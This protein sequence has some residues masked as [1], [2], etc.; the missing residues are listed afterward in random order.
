MHWEDPDLLV[1]EL[2]ALPSL[3]NATVESTDA[4][5][6]VDAVV[7]G[8]PLLISFSYVI[9]NKKPPFY[10]FGRSKKLEGITG[11][12]LNRILLR[13]QSFHWFLHGVPGLGSHVDEV[14]DKLKKLIAA[15]RPSQVWCIG[16]SMGGYAA[17][18]FGFL[19]H[20]DRIVAISPLSNFDAAQA[21]IYHEKRFMWAQDAVAVCP[22]ASG[23]YDLPQLARDVGYKGQLHLVIG[24]TGNVNAPDVVNID[25]MHAYRFGHVPGLKMYYVPEADHDY[26]TLLLQRAGK[27]DGVLLECLFDHPAVIE[28]SAVWNRFTPRV[29]YSPPGKETA[30][31]KRRRETAAGAPA[32]SL[33][34]SFPQLDAN[35]VAAAEAA[36]K[37]VLVDKVVQHAPLLICFAESLP[38]RNTGFEFFATSKTL[39]SLHGGPINRVLLRDP[40]CQWWLRGV[41]ELGDDYAPVAQGLKQFIDDIEPERV[42]CVGN[43]MG[44]YAAIMFAMLLQADHA[45]ALNPLSLLDKEFASLCHDPRHRDPLERLDT[46]PAASGPRDLLQLADEQAYAGKLDIL[47][48]TMQSVQ[49]WH[50]G[51]HNAVHAARLGLLPNTKLHPWYETLDGELLRWLEYRKI[52]APQLH[53]VAF[54]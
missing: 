7:P 19:L 14:A 26:V 48:S 53:R 37:A 2:A 25:V 31:G 28:S 44:A 43:G 3:D 51:N 21:R 41:Q 38:D 54:Q 18:M 17:A 11:Q 40:Q 1:A 45:V 50:V 22:P 30:R 29:A 12:A 6:L 33:R 27:I 36:G 46:M 20:A 32:A 8:T 24:T 34:Y 15:I 4:D 42:V 13:D 9:W 5:W 16:D 52:L 35:A 49:T 23:Y 47:F 39:E 10:M